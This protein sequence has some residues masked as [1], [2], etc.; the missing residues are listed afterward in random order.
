LTLDVRRTP[1]LPWAAALNIA[2]NPLLPTVAEAMRQ[3]LTAEV[4][5][6]LSAHLQP[7]VEH[8]DGKQRIVISYLSAPR[9]HNQSTR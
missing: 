5:D 7:Q 9:R 4:A 8:G 1:A 2:A 3:A 6:R